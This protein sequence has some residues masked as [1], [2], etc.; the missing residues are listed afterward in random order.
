MREFGS[1]CLLERLVV[2]CCSMFF[3]LIVEFV[4]YF[5]SFAVSVFVFVDFI[6]YFVVAHVIFFL[7]IIYYIHVRSFCARSRNKWPLAIYYS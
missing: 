5:I 6:S 4:V 1:V 7:N 2:P 3:S